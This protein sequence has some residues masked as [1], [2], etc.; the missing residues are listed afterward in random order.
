MPNFLRN[1]W[2][3]G[4]ASGP[5]ADKDK[6][7]D[8]KQKLESRKNSI[9]QL[10]LLAKGTVDGYQAFLVQQSLDK[11][12]PPPVQPTVSMGHSDYKFFV[13]F[14]RV[15]YIR[16]KQHKDICTKMAEEHKVRVDTEGAAVLKDVD[17]LTEVADSLPPI[18]NSNVPYSEY[19]VA[20]CIY[21]LLSMKR[22]GRRMLVLYERNPPEWDPQAESEEESERMMEEVKKDE[23]REWYG[24]A[25]LKRDP[26][27][28]SL[29]SGFAYSGP[30]AKCGKTG[31]TWKYCCGNQPMPLSLAVEGLEEEEGIGPSS[32]KKMILGRFANMYL[33]NPI[34]PK[35]EHTHPI[36][37]LPD[38]KHI[39]HKDAHADK[40]FR[41]GRLSQH[42]R[43]HKLNH[44]MPPPE[45]SPRQF[46]HDKPIRDAQRQ[47]VKPKQKRT[48]DS[49][50]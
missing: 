11:E 29:S 25:L 18:E 1:L 38:L 50:F 14:R 22:H 23:A 2:P 24:R 19:E 41:E 32:E 4:G 40:F 30:L 27:N 9:E 3:G 31:L 33:V 39:M 48:A 28:C 46:S 6:S 21:A 5:A 12:E 45:G 10:E 13:D 16:N 26:T 42:R 20:D 43:G 8:D 44:L 34:V 49:R 15:D 36:T 35:V 7:K 37:A 17:F 47:Q